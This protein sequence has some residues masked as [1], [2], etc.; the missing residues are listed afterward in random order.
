MQVSD[1]SGLTLAAVSPQATLLEAAEAM[2]R[3]DT[4]AVLV[5][6]AERLLGI[7]RLRSLFTAPLPARSGTRVDD[8][9]TEQNL[10]E[11]WRGMTVAQVMNEQAL[12]VTEDY[13]LMKAA[14]LILNNEGE[15]VAVTRAGKVLGM[16]SKTDV[17]RTLLSDPAALA[18]AE[19]GQAARR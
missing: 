4:D 8:R 5:I 12:T 6:Q 18:E 7:V 14:A 10:E 3:F 15:P 16:L 2:G 19:T 17:V 13:P 11:L 9:R 1:V